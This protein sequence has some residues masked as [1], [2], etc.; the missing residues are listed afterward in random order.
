[1]RIHPVFPL[2]ILLIISGTLFFSGQLNM[3]Q[4]PQM[5]ISVVAVAGSVWLVLVGYRI[6]AYDERESIHR[7]VSY[8][9]AAAAGAVVLGLGVVWE[10]INHRLDLWLIAA[11]LAMA[12]ARVLSHWY[13]DKHN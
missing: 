9:W 7:S 1:M 3:P 13:L 12:S 2:V 4:T 8:Q 6:N 11:A 10:L 5:I